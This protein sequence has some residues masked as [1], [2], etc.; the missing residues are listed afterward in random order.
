MDMKVVH[1]TISQSEQLRESPP[2]SEEAFLSLLCSQCFEDEGLR[3]TSL[4][5]GVERDGPCPNCGSL[6]GLKLDRLR[7]A[8][9]VSVFFTA[10]TL[11]RQEYG[12][13]PVLV[14]NEH[15]KTSV[16]LA[17]WSGQDIE[18][19]SEKSGLGIFF[20]GPR[21][22]MLGEVEPLKD[23][24]S[25]D[26]RHT[27]ID[28]ILTEYPT[29]VLGTDTHFYRM[30]RNPNDST[31][32]GEF[33]SP[34]DE[35][36]GAGRLDSPGFPVLYGSQ[37]IQVCVHECRTTVDDEIFIATVV[38]NRALKLLDLTHVLREEGVTEF[39][40][41]DLAVHMLFLAKR[42]SY[43]IS[44]AIAWGAKERGFDGVIYPS[45]FSLLRTGARPFETVIGMSIRHIPNLN[46]YAAKQMIAN[47]AIFGRPIKDG[48]LHVK[49]IN[50]VVMVQAD[51]LLT[52]GP[53]GYQSK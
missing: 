26:R 30:R 37:D 40:S 16:K 43:E 5:F 52:F 48:L 6:R 32:L 49:S 44:R 27:I 33:D 42:H 12:G 18:L 9:L 17:Q 10:G 3:L 1:D 53:V 20:Y 14:S 29:Q 35:F 24:I 45:Y 15:Q 36:C 11:Q 21:L 46:N 51:Y 39:E 4:L 50:R 34:P 2:N 7:A 38:P 19:L 41:L 22:W 8:H 25:E 13:S 23:L 28:R 31:S 47:V